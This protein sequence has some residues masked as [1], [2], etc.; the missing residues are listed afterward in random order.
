M[1][2]FTE[3]SQRYTTHWSFFALRGILYIICAL[4]LLFFP[5]VSMQLLIYTLGL[6]MMLDGVG[7]ASTA[8]LGNFVHI[9]KRVM[10]WKNLIQIAL[11]AF[12]FTYP[13]L[14]QIALVWGLGALLIFR[15]V[16]EYISLIEMTQLS[17]HRSLMMGPAVFATLGI[18]TLFSPFEGYHTV[19]LFVGVYALLEGVFRVISA[20]RLSNLIQ[21]NE[22]LSLLSF[23]RAANHMRP[24]QKRLFAPLML[25]QSVPDFGSSL[26]QL[27]LAR[28]RN[29]LVFV[30]HPDD[31]EGFVGGLAYQAQGRVTQ[32]IFC[33]G[34]RGVWRPAYRNL[35][36]ETY[37]QMRL[38][39]AEEAARLLGID[40]VRYMGYRDR[41]LVCDDDSIGR[42]LDLIR[43][44]APDCIISFEYF[45]RATPYTHADH[46]TMANI[47]RHAVARYERREQVD[48]LL[49]STFLP[50]RFMDV[51]TVRRVK[52][53]ALACHLS[54][55]ELTGAIFP[56]FEKVLT[57]LWGAFIGTRYAEGYRL[58]D[59]K[60]LVQHLEFESPA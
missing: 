39:E 46:L 19:A 44:Y 3:L 37:I 12:I 42:T 6:G 47:V 52:L 25:Q 27:D 51:T 14:V 34:D 21:S 32:V 1:L 29:I 60:A 43:D 28:Y 13:W 11:G 8:L 55:I 30:P 59:P 23:R 16:L 22:R 57:R 35:P 48:F 56:L 24:A 38:D 26:T 10:L 50:N 7:G 17:T 36:K 31:L 54:Q 58:V 20:V 5:H 45:R 2:Y 9:L 53:S 40:E 18:A 15:A 33:G 4:A 41:E 49:T